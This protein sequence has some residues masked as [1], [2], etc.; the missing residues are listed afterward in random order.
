MPDHVGAGLGRGEADV[1]DG[2]GRQ[3]Q[4]L[5]EGAQH[6]PDHRHVLGAG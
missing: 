4:G 6:V 2:V 5:A 1:L 3:M